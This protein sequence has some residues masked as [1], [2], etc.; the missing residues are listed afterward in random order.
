MAGHLHGKTKQERKKAKEKERKYQINE[1]EPEIT[2]AD[3]MEE[4][5]GGKPKTSPGPDMITNDI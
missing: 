4:I 5:K 1:E 3:F 2:L